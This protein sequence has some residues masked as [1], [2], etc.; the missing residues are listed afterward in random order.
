MLASGY[1][2]RPTRPCGRIAKGGRGLAGPL[3]CPPASQEMSVGP[4]PPPAPA[5]R[6][7]REGAT[8]PRRSAAAARGLESSSVDDVNESRS[9]RLP[10]SRS[11]SLVLDS[12]STRPRSVDTP[13][14]A[15]TSERDSQQH[16]RVCRRERRLHLRARARCSI[17]LLRAWRYPRRSRCRSIHL[18]SASD[19]ERW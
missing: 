1:E 13:R 10:L 8:S 14:R 17:A 12:S 3:A 11:A 6:D 16:A 15:P 5:A 9:S 4:L 2:G 19:C 7:A 18:R